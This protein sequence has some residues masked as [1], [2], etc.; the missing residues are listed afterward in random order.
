[1]RRILFRSALCEHRQQRHRRKHEAMLRARTSRATCNNTGRVL[2][3]ITPAAAAAA[4]DAIASAAATPSGWLAAEHI[5]DGNAGGE[6]GT[7][8]DGDARAIDMHLHLIMN[9]GICKEGRFHKQRIHDCSAVKNRT[10]TILFSICSACGSL[11]G[12]VTS[13]SDATSSGV[14]QKLMMV[15]MAEKIK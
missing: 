7:N 2:E 12:D 13:R 10:S 4:A 3:F 5:C 1:M 8:D 15:S 14:G 6:D 9:D 11:A